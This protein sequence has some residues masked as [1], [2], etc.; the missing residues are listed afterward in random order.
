MNTIDRREALKRL[1]L[2]VGG[3]ISAPVVSALLGGCTG[4]GSRPPYVFETLSP[5]Q[6]NLLG[7]I[8][9]LIIPE[10]DTPGAR[11]AGAERF[12]DEIL[13]HWY[14]EE[15]KGRFMEGLAGFNAESFL[16][17]TPEAQTAILE[18][19]DVEAV[20]ARE[21]S[22]PVPFFGMLKELVVVAYYT[23][24]IGATQELRRQV[25]FSAYEGNV[26]YNEGDRAWSGS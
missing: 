6:Q 16:G 13:S 15:E 5:E 1:S 9:D 3:A 21:I 12:V 20:A 19:L 18:L 10:T 22:E 26:P 24:E 7:T 4:S 17:E 2:I 25:I 8:A 14:D 23:S 11:A